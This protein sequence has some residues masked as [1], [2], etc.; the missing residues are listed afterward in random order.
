[1]TV[2]A[3][4]HPTL[5][6]EEYLAVEEASDIRHEYV[7]GVTHAL[8]GTSKRHNR[9]TLNIARQLMDAAAGGPCRVYS[10]DVKLR[11][12]GDVIYYPDVMVSCGPE[13]TDP[14]IEDAPCLVVEVAS[15][16]T[17]IIDQREKLLAY[18]RIPT[19]EAYLIV[20]QDRR[21]VHRFWRD[22]DGIWSDDEVSGSGGVS[23]PCPRTTLRLDDI[24]AGTE[25][26]A[27]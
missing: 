4:R 23:V 27:G 18:K 8:A 21:R 10:I 2:E 20:E 26:P 11:A 3:L 5:T 19:I 24:Y 17:S 6:L 14:L 9:I 13:G 22:R 1:M 7:G 16:S 12:E 25:T 15:P